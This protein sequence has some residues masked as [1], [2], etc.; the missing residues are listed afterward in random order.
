MFENQVC[1][2]PWSQWREKAGTMVKEREIPQDFNYTRN[3]TPIVKCPKAI[4][5]VSR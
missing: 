4:L 3:V 2:P 1:G 5:L